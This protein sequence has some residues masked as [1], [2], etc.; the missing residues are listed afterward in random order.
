MRAW[1]FIEIDP[2]VTSVRLASFDDTRKP[3][4][5]LRYLN[6]QKLQRKRREAEFARKRP[7][8]VDMYGD[9]ER[10]AEAV[11]DELAREEDRHEIEMLKQEME[12]LKNQIAVQIDA[13]EID[14]ERKESIAQGAM[15]AIARKRKN[16]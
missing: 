9:P 14:A 2:T 15:R 3:R 5:T 16:Q 12:L 6:K 10:Q 4:I 8:I 7:L 13:A 1:E 11:K